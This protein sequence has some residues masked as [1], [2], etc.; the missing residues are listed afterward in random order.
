MKAAEA[1]IFMMG[2]MNPQE[3]R[4]FILDGYHSAQDQAVLVSSFN[5]EEDAVEDLEIN[6]EK[7]E[8]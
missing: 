8:E 4:Q 5:P 7:K 1:I 2:C 6:K 3:C